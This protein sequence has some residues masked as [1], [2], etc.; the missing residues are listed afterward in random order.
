MTTQDDAN[1][2][3]KWYTRVSIWVVGAI[4]AGI[5]AFVSA[6]VASLLDSGVEHIGQPLDIVTEHSHECAARQVILNSPDHVPPKPHPDDGPPELH[7]YDTNSTQY[8][9]WK[10]RYQEWSQRDRQLTEEW[11]RK[12]GVTDGDE[13]DLTVTVT[14]KSD[15]PVILRSLDVEVTDR[16]TPSRYGFTLPSL[17]PT[18]PVNVRYVS[19]DLD[20][21]PPVLIESRDKRIIKSDDGGNRFGEPSP[22]KPITFP[23]LVSRT[24][25]E[26][27]DLYL[28]TTTC[29]CSWRL[30][31]H[32]ISGGRSGE[33]T[34]D[35]NGQ[36]FR[37]V[38]ARDLIFGPSNP[39]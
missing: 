36:P 10:R 21:N 13:T 20:K 11:E 14:G 23:Y 22:D 6:R 17:C 5:A 35:D 16:R 25:L 28:R 19:F 38:P 1:K 2:R 27:F 31:L 7:S 37:T 3:K 33:L 26:V 39:R 9:E 12:V 8:K 34:I 15:H 32:W 24:E 29:D 30:H 4:L 18:K